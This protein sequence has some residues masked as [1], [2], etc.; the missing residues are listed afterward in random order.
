[1]SVYG[2]QY[3]SGSGVCILV[4]LAACGGACLLGL[5]GVV[6][7][8]GVGMFQGGTMG[9]CWSL[10]GRPIE[11]CWVGLR[12]SDNISPPSAFFFFFFLIPSVYI[13]S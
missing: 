10:R 12:V 6:E 11:P 1:M 3:G 4:T 2:H 8:K 5:S 9:V 13:V 7:G